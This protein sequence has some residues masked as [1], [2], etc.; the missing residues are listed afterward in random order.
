MKNARASRSQLMF[1]ILGTILLT[2]IACSIFSGRTRLDPETGD[3]VATPDDGILL[4]VNPQDCPVSETDF[5]EYWTNYIYPDLEFANCN[6]NKATV[7]IYRNCLKN[8]V[9][10]NGTC[11]PDAKELCKESYANIPQNTSGAGGEVVSTNL[12]VFHSEAEVNGANISFNNNGG[13]V[14][15]NLDYVI[16]DSHLCTITVFINL[17][18]YFNEHYCSMEGDAS[19]LVTYAGASCAS[20][21]SSS[22]DA[23]VN[24]PVEIT[25]SVPWSATLDAGKLSGSVGGEDCEPL[26]IG[27]SGTP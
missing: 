5:D 18:G 11:I 17:N 21:C 6:C 2:S 27:F 7:E 1:L 15:G 12:S 13:S 9:I 8:Q 19:L 16:K 10:T 4:E 25:A 23:E 22:P 26:C 3:V 24:C 14:S 20:V